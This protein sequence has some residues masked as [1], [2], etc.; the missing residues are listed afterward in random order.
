M[1]EDVRE[2]GVAVT[3]CPSC[4]GPVKQTEQPDGSVAGEP[5]PVCYPDATPV[6]SEK[7]AETSSVSRERGTDV[8]EY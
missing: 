8:K 1:T 6:A 5:C 2:T 4:G 7:A 3:T